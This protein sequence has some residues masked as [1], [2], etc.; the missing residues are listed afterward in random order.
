MTTTS[1]FRVLAADG[2][3][4]YPYDGQSDDFTPARNVHAWADGIDL[5]A[6]G[7]D[8]RAAKFLAVPADRTV[9][10][11]TVAEGRPEPIGYHRHAEVSPLPAFVSVEGWA[12]FSDS[13]G[14]NGSGEPVAGD[15][16]R[17]ERGPQLYRTAS[18]ELSGFVDFPI[19]VL[20]PTSIVDPDGTFSWSVS[21]P[22]L[23][24][25]TEYANALPGTLGGI[26]DRFAQDVERFATHAKVWT[27]KA[28][29]GVVDG[30][31]RLPYDDKRTFMQKRGRREVPVQGWKDIQFSYPIPA[32]IAGDS[33]TQAIA[34]YRTAV[35][36]IV[37]SINSITGQVCAACNGDGLVRA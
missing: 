22:Y 24:F 31:V 37:A 6:N 36:D 14:T 35:A 12:A 34:A 16:Y 17:T 23:V 20:D 29:E 13:L 8:Y 28:K 19:D 25:G 10:E 21:A 18:I 7:T 4:L 11:F 33:K 3:F 27:H 15:L 2:R 26:R 9:A 32:N 5:V 1:R 30:Y